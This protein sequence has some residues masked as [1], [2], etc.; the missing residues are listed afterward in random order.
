MKKCK[1]CGALLPLSEYYDTKAGKFS[2][3][4]ECVR[5]NVKKNRADKEEYYKA[6]D[7]NR[8]DKEERNKATLDRQ[9]TPEGKQAHNKRNKEWADRNTKQRAANYAVSNAVRDGVLKKLPCFVCGDLEVEGHHPDY[10]TPLDVVWL[11]T[12]HHKEI[13]RKYDADKDAR[14][15]FEKVRREG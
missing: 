9:K 2:K 7:R 8:P 3:C 4:K 15:L 11:C 12:A 10:D 6:Y 13:H 14:I 5:E 1:Q